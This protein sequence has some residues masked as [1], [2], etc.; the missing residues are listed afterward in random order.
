MRK[1][2]QPEKEKSS[3]LPGI[4]KTRLVSQVLQDS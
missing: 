3:N 1:Q 2:L 4:H